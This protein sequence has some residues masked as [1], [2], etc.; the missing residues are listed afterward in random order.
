MR[1][2]TFLIWLL[3]APPLANDDWAALRTLRRGEPVVIERTGG[4]VIAGRFQCATDSAV[5]IEK[6][7]LRVFL[8]E[9]VL[10]IDRHGQRGRSLYR[11]TALAEGGR[12]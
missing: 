10:N 7:G 9:D 6:H 3:A 4:H 12:R 2:L 8:R 11:R 1:T 5:V